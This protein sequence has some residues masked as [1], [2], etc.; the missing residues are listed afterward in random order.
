M[1]RMHA[2][3]AKNTFVKAKSYNLIIPVLYGSETWSLTLRGTSVFRPTR[4]EAS[5]E[6]GK[7]INEELQALSSSPDIIGLM[8]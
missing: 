5:R 1:L 2:D 8:K 3:S 7:W 6:W 4:E